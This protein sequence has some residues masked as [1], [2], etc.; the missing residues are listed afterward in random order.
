MLQRGQ[1]GAVGA[2]RR[3]DRLLRAASSATK[4]LAQEAAAATSAAAAAP[5]PPASSGAELAS[6]HAPLAPRGAP[7]VRERVLADIRSE[8]PVR[9]DL[10]AAAS[11][12]RAASAASAAASLRQDRL[13][14]HMLLLCAEP[15]AGD[16]ANPG[17]W[18]GVTYADL[19]A[20]EAAGASSGAAHFG[21]TLSAQELADAAVA[22]AAATA[23]KAEDTDDAEADVLAA[24][25]G[26][27]GKVPSSG[28]D[29][30]GVSRKDL[31]AVFDVLMDELGQPMPKR[32]SGGG[33]AGAASSSSPSPTA[34]ASAEA[35]AAASGRPVFGVPADG[36]EPGFDP[37]VDGSPSVLGGY[38]PLPS[39]EVSPLA[40]AWL[41]VAVA[42]LEGVAARLRAHAAA[43]PAAV[44][45]AT[46]LVPLAGVDATHAEAVLSSLTAVPAVPVPEGA[47]AWLAALPA[48]KLS[49]VMTHLL[50]RRRGLALPLGG[51]GGAA[52]DAS[53]L[54]ARL[55][56]VEE[57]AG[58]LRSARD[59]K[60]GG[61]SGSGSSGYPTLRQ[62]HAAL[63]AAVGST[64]GGVPL[65][66]PLRS[67][68]AAQAARFRSSLA[69]EQ[70]RLDAA[71]A[72]GR[73]TRDALRPPAGGASARPVPKFT[74]SVP[75]ASAV[76]AAP[77]F[78][79]E[80]VAVTAAGCSDPADDGAVTVRLAPAHAHARALTK[81]HL[82]SALAPLAAVL[83]PSEHAALTS[84]VVMA[85]P[86]LR[87]ALSHPLAVDASGKVVPPPGA[88]GSVTSSSS[89]S[90]GEVTVASPPAPASAS[91]A[92][93][94]SLAD[95][96]DH[97]ARSRNV[98]R[99][100][101]AESASRAALSDALAGL[102]AAAASGALPAGF[103]VAAW[104]DYVSFVLDMSGSSAG[105]GAAVPFAEGREAVVAQMVKASLAALPAGVR[106]RLAPV[107]DPILAE[108]D[109]SGMTY[110]DAARGAGALAAARSGL[111]SDAEALAVA[112]GAGFGDAT[113]LGDPPVDSSAAI[114][115]GA[116]AVPG[117]A[118]PAEAA[119]GAALPRP[120]VRQYYP[121]TK[122]VY[123]GPTGTT[124]VGYAPVATRHH[125]DLVAVGMGAM[126]VGGAAR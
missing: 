95:F 108:L 61:S 69:A 82:P 38:V 121:L 67:A 126:C 53:L 102:D 46:G 60:L 103:D 26:A 89:G 4:P 92:T 32:G 104:K 70:A 110:D 68:A 118:A 17:R 39:T 123:G 49:A 13:M 124:I 30:G 96:A 117:G 122:P 44:K 9:A 43:A 6:L 52:P 100:I 36:G 75:D 73:K 105:G 120:V 119:G 15:S 84:L 31:D 28:A 62:L 11:T 5:P 51:G 59:G 94:S 33:A 1:A 57:A 87:E 81:G 14:A 85:T 42:H 125:D 80:T 22:R 64:S 2:A 93:G 72:H 35:E 54:T 90:D 98:R 76:L 113:G 91:A 40:T 111:T 21:K 83:T 74:V 48:P 65:F 10:L 88:S 8:F 7:G 112:A 47:A 107:G 79:P 23:G 37:A 27:E 56:A 19:A 106:A 55:K 29:V 25:D 99:A 50:L 78:A 3:G 41:D 71:V 115:G 114:T 34:A 45:S 63:E 109:K 66:T 86:G 12:H 16:L 116:A 58:V 18:A 101:E 77:G 20:A 97:L 24:L